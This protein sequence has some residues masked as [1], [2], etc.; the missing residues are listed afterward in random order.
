MGYKV[1][2][3]CDQ[4]GTGFEWPINHPVAISIAKSVARRSGWSVGKQWLCQECRVKLPKKG[5]RND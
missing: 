2:I 4:C 3:T 5:K 1:T